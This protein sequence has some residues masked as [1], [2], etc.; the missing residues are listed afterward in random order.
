MSNDAIV[1][2]TDASFEDD[3]LQA[4]Q[5]VLVDFWTAWC[6]H[7][8]MKAPTLDR[9]GRTYKGKIKIAKMDEDVNKQTTVNYNIGGIPTLIIFKNGETNSTKVGALSKAQLVES[10][11]DAL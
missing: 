8:K 3:V 2:V 9:L 4:S 6:V 11:D 7:C 10:I 5:P 1:H